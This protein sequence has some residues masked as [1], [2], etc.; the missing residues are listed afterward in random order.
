MGHGD[1]ACLI[2]N[3]LAEHVT[4]LT[5]FVRARLECGERCLYVCGDKRMATIDGKLRGARW[6]WSAEVWGRVSSLPGLFNSLTC[7]G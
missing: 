2:Y 6:M 1:H 7:G 4:A 5:P 3:T